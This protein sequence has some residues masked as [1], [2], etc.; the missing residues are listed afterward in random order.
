M[1]GRDAKA[2]SACFPRAALGL[3]QL[4]TAVITL[5]DAGTEARRDASAAQRSPAPAG[6]GWVPPLCS[7]CAKVVQREQES[8]PIYVTG[9]HRGGVAAKPPHWKVGVNV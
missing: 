5:G 4:C 3:G 2:P 9:G 6:A 1:S 7:G 8:K